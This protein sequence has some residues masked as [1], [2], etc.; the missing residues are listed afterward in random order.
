MATTYNRLLIDVNQKINDIVTAKQNDIASRFLD[1]SLYSNSVPINLTGHSVK[2]YFKK[3]D[4]TQ[5]FTEGE[6][7]DATAGRCQFELTT[8]T[9]SVYGDLKVEI[10]IWNGDTQVLTTQTFTITVFEMLRS[11]NTV[12]S[13]NEFGVLVTLF[14]SIQNALDAMNAIKTNFGAAGEKAA[15]YGATT[16][17]EM[18]EI[19]AGR[20]EEA[21]QLDVSGKIGEPADTTDTTVFGKL[22]GVGDVFTKGISPISESLMIPKF[23]KAIIASGSFTI[24]KDGTYKIIACGAGGTSGVGGGGCA[25]D[26]REY[27]EG[28]VLTLTVSGSAS[29]VCSARSLSITANGTT[30]TAGAT[31]S[32]GN[33]A[34]YTGGSSVSTTSSRNSNGCG[35]GGYFASASTAYGGSGGIIGG[36]GYS[37]SSENMVAYGG[38]GG[39]I[40]GYGGS[41][42]YGAN[43]T[44]LNGGTGIFGG[45]G[46][47][48]SSTSSSKYGGNGGNGIYVGGNGGNATNASGGNGGNGGNGGVMGGNGGNT[49][50]TSSNGGIGGNAGRLKGGNY[51]LTLG[52]A[53]AYNGMYWTIPFKEVLSWTKGNAIIFIEEV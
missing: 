44:A 9:L 51:S 10:S 22:N 33:V 34:N 1:V 31:A 39:I 45:N 6:I 5:V 50:N 46:G 16:F 8:Q 47:N 19:L 24:P 25:I 23:T 20:T 11:D 13:T 2:I 38:D 28:D 41:A 12:E 3:P 21:I 35:A 17:W 37:G 15:E 27:F 29:V 49:A 48:A 32:G 4:N 40:G 36:D 7:T 26:Q 18:L 43:S 53:G 52:G 14:Q 30:T 42:S